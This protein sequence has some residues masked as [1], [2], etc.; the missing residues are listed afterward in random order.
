MGAMAY[1]LKCPGESINTPDCDVCSPVRLS[2]GQDIIRDPV[3]QGF[4]MEF[5]I[6]FKMGETL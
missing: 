2:L 6:L 5:R 1:E 4:S 3:D